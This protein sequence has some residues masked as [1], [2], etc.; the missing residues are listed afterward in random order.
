MS[1]VPFYIEAYDEAGDRARAF[2]LGD[3]SKPIVA[4]ADLPGSISF[5]MSEEIGSEYRFRHGTLLF[6]GASVAAPV[7]ADPASG[8]EDV[9]L[10][11]ELVEIAIEWFTSGNSRSRS[12]CIGEGATTFG[13]NISEGGEK[14]PKAAMR[15]M[16]TG[17]LPN[18]DESKPPCAF[19]LTLLDGRT[20]DIF[21]MPAVLEAWNAVRVGRK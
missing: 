14:D 21:R 8:I 17:K 2:V 12:R 15:A 6:R 19:R 7:V 16:A 5:G 20:V 18:S 4:R 1:G 3:G 13:V 10:V 9:P 11:K